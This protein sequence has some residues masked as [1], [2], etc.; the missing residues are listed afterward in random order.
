MGSQG[1][2]CL[3]NKDTIVDITQAMGDGNGTNV[4]RLGIENGLTYV[5]K[6]ESFLILKDKNVQERINVKNSRDY[7]KDGNNLWIIDQSLIYLQNKSKQ[8][9]KISE[10][11]KL[12]DMGYTD[13]LKFKGKILVS[14]R[15]GL[16]VINNEKLETIINDKNG[17][18]KEKSIRCMYTD[19]ETLYIGT[20]KGVASTNDLVNFK[21][22]DLKNGIEECEIKCI[23]KD[24]NGLLWVGTTSKGI[25][26]IITSDIARYEL[27]SEP[28]SFS[29]NNKKQLFALTNNAILKYDSVTDNFSMFKEI[30]GVYNP[31][32]FCFD[33]DNTI[34]VTNGEKGFLKIAGNKQ[35]EFLGSNRENKFPNNA[36]GCAASD[37]Y[38]WLCFRKSILRINQSTQVV[39]TFNK[40]PKIGS[41]FQDVEASGEKAWISSDRGFLRFNGTAYDTITS[42]NCNGY[43][44]GITNC[45]ALDSYGHVWVGTDQ[46]LF[47]YENGKVFSNLRKSYFPTNEIADIA[48]LDSF[49]LVASGKGLIQL[50]IKPNSNQNCVF[51]I[52]NQR[53]GLTHVDLTNRRLISDGNYV[54]ITSSTGIY[55]YKPVLNNV[56]NIPLYISN[57]YN[58]TTSLVYGSSKNFIRKTVNINEPLNINYNQND[59]VIEFN[60]I[61]YHLFENVFY[62]YRLVGLNDNWSIPSNENKAVYTN[63]SHG[64][65]TFELSLSNG[66]NN[67]GQVISYQINISPPFYKTWWFRGLSIASL[68]VFILLFIQYRIKRIKQKNILLE[69]KVLDRTKELQEKS[70]ELKNSND[71]L[72]YKNSLITESLEYAKNIQE[73]ILPSEQFINTNFNSLFKVQ[74]IYQPKD[75]VGGD[76]YSAFKKGEHSYFALID[77]TG[78]GVPGALLTFSVHTL[79]HNIIDISTNTYKPSEILQRLLSDFFQVYVKGKNVDESFAISL[80]RINNNS[81]EMLVSSISQT[82]A[83]ISSNNLVEIKSSSSFFTGD[84]NEITDIPYQLSKGDR[85]YL[86]SDGIYDQKHHQ[87]NKRLFKS[88]FLELLKSS[89]NLDCNKQRLFVLNSFQEFKGNSTQVDDVSVILIEVC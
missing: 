82:I 65:Y 68:V 39:D 15:E 28:L 76:F 7:Y 77:C 89:F 13:V 53:N 36:L 46:G 37:K 2:L 52:I 64:K 61:N 10:Q 47:C 81:K 26:K 35:T 9:I 20:K 34:Y 1:A 58:D 80:I 17:L 19:G 8:L 59:F 62:S 51:K 6:Y 32:N 23:T 78:H 16:V 88:N 60:G 69:K 12:K 41:Y 24:K 18:S 74:T 48:V 70:N 33:K 73:S 42:R 31:L 29:V 57:I 14:S 75:I 30:K 21:Y 63:L 84:N 66:K 72:A 40:R 79:L 49:L 71:Q 3:I 83:V 44:D 56:Y 38:V 27:E 87:T 25:Y 11:F 5:C 54:W 45:L 43:P 67:I 55:R 86:Y 85:I 22:Y 4:I 50:S